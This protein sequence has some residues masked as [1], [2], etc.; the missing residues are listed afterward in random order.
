M[1][2]KPSVVRLNQMNDEILGKLSWNKD[3]NRFEATVDVD[4][5]QLSF[6]VE[7]YDRKSPTFDSAHDHLKR[8]RSSPEKYKTAAAKRYLKIHNESW[9]DG[10]PITKTEFCKRLKLYAILVCEDPDYG[11]ADL[12]YHD[13]GLFDGHSVVVT[14]SDSDEIEDVKLFG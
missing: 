6:C 7:P 10:K 1:S 12:M 5:E 13:G 3:L 4:G 9:N 14:A 11:S 8:I 2:Q